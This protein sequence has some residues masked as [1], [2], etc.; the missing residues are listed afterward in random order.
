MIVPSSPYFEKC[1]EPCVEDMANHLMDIKISS[2][3]NYNI[4][5][6]SDFPFQ[7]FSTYALIR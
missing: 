7:S 5:M 2:H 4:N 6:K 1:Y 3:P